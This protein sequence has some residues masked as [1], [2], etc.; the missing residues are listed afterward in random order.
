MC[1]M[2][3]APMVR[4]AAVHAIRSFEMAAVRNL[5]EIIKLLSNENDEVRK[6]AVGTIG[7]IGAAATIPD[8]AI[9]LIPRL[10]EDKSATVRA[11]ACQALGNIG[12]A[13]DM[14]LEPLSCCLTDEDD[15]VRG[16]AVEAMG[17]ISEGL[18][19]YA[20]SLV[21]LVEGDPNWLVRRAAAGVLEQISP[22]GKQDYAALAAG[23]SSEIW[24]KLEGSQRGQLRHALQESS[25]MTLDDVICVKPTRHVDWALPS[26]LHSSFYGINGTTAAELEPKLGRAAS[27]PELRRSHRDDQVDLMDLKQSPPRSASS[28]CS[29]LTKAASERPFLNAS[30]RL[31]MDPASSPSSFDNSPPVMFFSF[32]THID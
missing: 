29:N 3:D 6:S 19:A 23:S 27:L 28:P 10:L 15:V 4:R 2:D 13:A 21:L 22:G 17:A 30:E 20:S 8:D 18:K 26:E 25:G 9:G 7:Q 1:L 12:A 31:K 24:D 16:A 32:F 14:H 5:D 11:A